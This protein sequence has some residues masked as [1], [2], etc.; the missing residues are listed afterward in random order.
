MQNDIY[1]HIHR[2][3]TLNHRSFSFWPTA[4]ERA[5]TTIKYGFTS[6]FH[7]QVANYL[8]VPVAVCC[9]LPPTASINLTSFGLPAYPLLSSL[10]SVSPPRHRLWVNWKEGLSAYMLWYLVIVC[11]AHLGM[12]GETYRSC[13]RLASLNAGIKAPHSKAELYL[14]LFYYFTEEEPQM[15][16]LLLLYINLA[17]CNDQTDS[18]CKEFV[19]V[20]F[21]MWGHHKSV[22]LPYGATRYSH[23]I[24]GGPYGC[25]K[26]GVNC[27]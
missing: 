9:E 11:A 15:M 3:H 10:A 26:T 20:N 7:R 18:Q 4:D 16:L 19:P 21:K 27:A 23:I 24:V 2:Q 17:L 5:R 6:C 22:L 12:I 8:Q 1:T 14:W 13:R 25:G